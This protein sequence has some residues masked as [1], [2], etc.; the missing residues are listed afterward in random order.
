MAT[1]ERLLINGEWVPAASG[2]TFDTLDPAT[3][4]PLATVADGGA[5][6]V[7]AAVAAATAAFNNP[8]WSEMPPAARAKILWKI[9]DLIDQH[10]AELAPLET[11][12]Q[13]QPIAISTNVSIPFAAEVFRYYAG[14]ATKIEGQ[15]VPLSIPGT[16]FY[17]RREPIGV[18]GLITPWNFPFMIAAWKI[19]PALA[20]GNTV[21]VKPAEQTP[22][23][24]LRLGQFCIDAGV[25]AGVVNIIT[26]G[27][28]AGKALVDHPG[29][30]KIS[31]TGSTEVGKSILR[32]SADNLT[33]VTLELG[34]KAPS[35]I[36]PDADLESA[37]VGNLQGALL[38]SGQVCKA[39]TRF[40]AHSSIADE[41]AQK[42]SD[43]AAT[44]P[45]GPG[46][47][48]D[49]V[50]GP[51]VSEEQVN[52]VSS[53]VDIAQ[54]EGAVLVGGGKR[55]GGE[56]ASGFFFEP[57][58]FKNVTDAMTI[59]KEEVF[60]PVLSVL[61]FDDEDEAIARANDSDYGLAASVWTSNLSAA[62]RM[63]AKIHAGTVYINTLPFLDPAAIHGG[64]GASGFGRE[65]GKGS[66]EEFTEEKGVWIGGI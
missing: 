56:L 58:V 24:T 15:Q 33:R 65:L 5:A 18:C 45:M 37:V 49:T 21:I 50:V 27:P 43:I 10:A 40:Y 4:A 47:S 12:D 36:M 7:D 62:H 55:A 42:L 35:I 46:S 32:S 64:F 60:G 26:G 59:A 30:K 39:Y 51:L 22:L 31:F 13:G 53:Y 44:L 66:I 38:N 8:E 20:T 23:S 2:A 14:W 9:A 25:P 16:L 6:D 57:T 11:K 41:F 29:V 17:T 52:Q 54:K 19:A 34:G 3:G 63:A 61:S 48:Q 28:E 1:S